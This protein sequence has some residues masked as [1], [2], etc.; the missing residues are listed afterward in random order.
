MFVEVQSSLYV[1]IYG[2]HGSVYLTVP[3]WVCILVLLFVCVHSNNN[4]NNI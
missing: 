4:N 2:V 3:H 1:Y